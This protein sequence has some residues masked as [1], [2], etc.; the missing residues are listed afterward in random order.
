MGEATGV[1]DRSAWSEALGFDHDVLGGARGS[2]AHLVEAA[3][4][5]RPG[6][7]QLQARPDYAALRP[8]SHRVPSKNGSATRAVT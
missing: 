5:L 2:L 8:Y 4:L 6:R 1:L 7:R 3:G